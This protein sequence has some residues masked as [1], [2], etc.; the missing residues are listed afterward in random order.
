MR[1]RTA[2]PLR[3]LLTRSR[4]V[5]R[6]RLTAAQAKPRRGG[7]RSGALVARDAKGYVSSPSP[8]SE[9]RDCDSPLLAR[10]F[11]SPAFKGT[12]CYSRGADHHKTAAPIRQPIGLPARP[13]ASHSIT[14]SA[15]ASSLS[16]TARPSA[17]A[18]L[19]L[20]TSS[21][22]VGCWT[23]KSPGF[24]PFSTLATYEPGPRYIATGSGPYAISTPSRATRG[25][26]Y[27]VGRP[28]LVLFSRLRC[29]VQRRRRGDLR[30]PCQNGP[31]ARRK[32]G[33]VPR[34]QRREPKRD[35]ERD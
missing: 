8:S 7:D 12:F 2:V 29:R 22:F 4:H 10:Q 16:G 35:P 9:R 14:S 13:V 19:R 30:G 27:I 20:I 3:R 32:P 5:Q 33:T 31:C 21:N 18:V 1:L 25:K 6:D 26:P 23:G 24:S 17:F 11:R 34:K 28:L 15:S